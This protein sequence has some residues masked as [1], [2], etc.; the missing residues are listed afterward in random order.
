M[1]LKIS[2]AQINLKVGDIQGNADRVLEA[3]RIAR[4]EQQAHAVVFPELTLTG[5][6]PE[7]LLLRPELI[8][9]VE[10]ELARICSVCSGIDL[11]LGYP[12][13]QDGKL[14]NAAGV[15][16]EG[17]IVAEYFKSLLPNYS[18]FDEKRYF[19]S[20]DRPCVFD[21]QGVPVGITI[22]EDIW[23]KTP[24]A[25]AAEAG[26]KILLNLNASPFHMGKAPERETL[27]QKRAQESGLSIIYLNLVGGQDELVFDGGSFVVS[28]EGKLV[29]RAEFFKEAQPVVE[30][31]EQ[32]G[33][34][35]PVPAQISP[36][37][38]EEQAVYSALVT[39]VRDYVLKNGFKGAVLGLSGGIDSA[40]TL[41]IAVDALGPEQVE[42]VLMP[43]RYTADMSNEDAILE[44]ELL[45]VKHQTIPIEP[46]FNTFLDMLAGPFT[47][48]QPDTTEENIQARCRGVL[49]MA[50]SNKSGKILLTTGNKSE[51][52]VGYATLYGDMA[53]GFAPIKDVPKLL[54]YRLA[55]YR[56]QAGE[57]IPRRV[58][59]RPPSAE[60][61][62]DQKDSDSLPPYEVLDSI[63][64]RYIEQDQ[65][66]AEIVS[67]GFS[68]QAVRQVVRLVD[69]NEY[70]RR[71]APPG[72]KITQ[73]AFGRDRRY[74]LTNGF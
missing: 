33:R 7:D 66:V 30:F 40:L 16:R 27:L 3:M 34:F 31:E 9:R 29:Q 6:P 26:A 1:S 18:V 59:E 55:E 4:D 72:V 42:V 51:M 73:R 14:Y 23:Y 65:G 15:I 57:V 50:I 24:A 61:A 19:E 22:C 21:L 10:R 5:Y 54:V 49:L 2:L 38:P 32:S 35:L 70:K 48:T 43:S 36:I 39:G 46:A 52:S 41:A 60:L 13:C 64:A 56:N 47:G 45:G 37:L 58:I 17:Q 44:A 69:R 28:P 74:P 53:G 68:E 11:I 71:Q 8:E 20:G 62:P 12:R 67:A 25:E 63:L